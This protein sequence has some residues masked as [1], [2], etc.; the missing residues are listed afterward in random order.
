VLG[1]MG[2]AGFNPLERRWYRPTL[3]VVG[4]WGGFTG[5]GQAAMA[6]A[7]RQRHVAIATKIETRCHSHPAAALMVV[8]GCSC[9]LRALHLPPW[10]MQLLLELF[11]GMLCAVPNPLVLGCFHLWHA[12]AFGCYSQRSVL[13]GCMCDLSWMCAVLLAHQQ[14]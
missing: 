10:A 5:Q 4:M 6:A 14:V 7:T 13:L 11:N 9:V 12:I 1:F 3:E 2:E 8:H